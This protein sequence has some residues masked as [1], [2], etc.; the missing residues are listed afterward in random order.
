MQSECQP[1]QVQRTADSRDIADGVK[2]FEGGKFATTMAL[3]SG[4]LHEAA[5]YEFSEAW[6]GTGHRYCVFV[7]RCS[8]F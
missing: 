7:M 6:T 3:V 4:M 8:G 2:A 1:G 5:S